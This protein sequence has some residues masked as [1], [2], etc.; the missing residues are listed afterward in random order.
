MSNTI[1][2]SGVLGNSSLTLDNQGSI[3][4]QNGTLT[5][6]TALTSGSPTFTNEGSVAALSG[7]TLNI[8]SAV[9]NK[10]TLAANGGT[11]NVTNDVS[12]TGSVTITAGGLANFL[13][14]FQQNVTFNGA[15]TLVL[16]HSL[17]YGGTI[18]GF[19][20]GE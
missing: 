19:G 7:S 15:G 12:D 2:G 9:A 16:G 10:G 5:V 8:Q 6:T 20:I 13:A 18:S 11:L 3:E 17:S 4:S 1:I 14:A